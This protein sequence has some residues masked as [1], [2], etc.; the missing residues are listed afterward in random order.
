MCTSTT[1]PGSA[2]VTWIGPVTGQAPPSRSTTSS[3]T[4]PAGASRLTSPHSES[5][6]ST[7]MRSPGAISVTG[8]A[9]GSKN[10]VVWSRVTRRNGHAPVGSGRV[11][12]TGPAFR[13]AAV[14]LAVGRGGGGEALDR[15]AEDPGPDLAAVAARQPTVDDRADAGPGD[16]HDVDAD[17]RAAEPEVRDLE[18]RMLGH[19]DLVHVRVHADHLLRRAALVGL[20]P[21]GGRLRE[22]PEPDGLGDVALTAYP[23][24]VGVGEALEQLAR[25]LGQRP[26]EPL[27][28]QAADPDRELAAAD[29]HR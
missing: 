7:T 14:F 3:I 23:L 12:G 18:V 13:L 5:A 16:L 9:H 28:A 17:R 2:P 21:E 11:H 10:I 25:G 1:P 15:C 22:T 29:R 24:H 4:K 19:G 6:V 20:Q 26:A 27:V 8:S